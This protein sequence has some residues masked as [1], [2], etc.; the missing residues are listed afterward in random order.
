MAWRPARG[1]RRIIVGKIKS[2]ASSTVFSYIENG[3]NEAKQFGFVCFP[4]FPDT[5]KEYSTNVMRTLS[6]RVNNSERSD[7]DDYYRFWEIPKESRGN[8]YRMLAYTG[9]ILATDNF[10][11]IADFYSIRDLTLV[12]E[13][14]GLSICPLENGTISEGD[15]LQWKHEKE[16]EYDSHAI[17]LYKGDAKIGYV[18]RIHSLIFFKQGKE[19]LSVTVKK[20]ESNGHINKAYIAIRSL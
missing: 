8:I 11:F 2:N 9:G 18:K 5:S 14:S 17:A 19:R 15:T 13:V 12:S 6:Q 3:V 20:I 1:K 7:I 4:D 10:E 16:N